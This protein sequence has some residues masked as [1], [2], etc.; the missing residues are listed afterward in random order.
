MEVGQWNVEV[1]Q[2]GVGTVEHGKGKDDR[3]TDGREG[4]LKLR[5]WILG[6]QVWALV[7][8]QV[9]TGMMVTVMMPWMTGSWG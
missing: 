7:G 6:A 9:K 4:D 2:R 8:Q 1:K 3:G 5:G